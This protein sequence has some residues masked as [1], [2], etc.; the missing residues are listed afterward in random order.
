MTAQ[1]QTDNSIVIRPER[2][3]TA[4]Y[5]DAF[6]Q[7]LQE[8]VAGGQTEIT[9]DLS[10]VGMLDSKGLAVFML[11]HK[12]LQAVGGRLVVVADNEDFRHLFHVMRMDEHFTVTGTAASE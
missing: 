12:S 5:A 3:I 9:I 6:R 7:E 1:S 11:C 8:L 4:S 10:G 2:D